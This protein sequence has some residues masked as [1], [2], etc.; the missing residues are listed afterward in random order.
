[1]ATAVQVPA[2]W[3]LPAQAHALIGRDQDVEDACGVL[4]RPDCSLLTLVGP[5]GIGKTR[6]ALR[7]AEA[8]GRQFDDGACF[9]DLTQIEDGAARPS[10]LA[11]QLGFR[12]PDL[13]TLESVTDY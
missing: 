5:G 12:S 3:N 1:M 9:V 10:L 11:T 7:V 2:H 4:L 13:S 8:L 6:L